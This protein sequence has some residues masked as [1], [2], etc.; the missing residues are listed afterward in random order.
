M[1]Q[2]TNDNSSLFS[3]F[4]K[5]SI[6][7]PSPKVQQNFMKVTAEL[8]GVIKSG[9][10]KNNENANLKKNKAENIVP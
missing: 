7:A 10:S 5:N 1:N 4:I 9:S 8:V 2:L 3:N 6:K